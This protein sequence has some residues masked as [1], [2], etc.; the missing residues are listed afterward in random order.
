MFGDYEDIIVVNSL[1]WN[2]Q[3]IYALKDACYILSVSEDLYN[4]YYDT[5]IIL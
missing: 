2:A 3:S 5:N 4:K 1:E